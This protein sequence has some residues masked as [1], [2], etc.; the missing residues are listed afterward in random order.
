MKRTPAV[1]AALAATAALAFAGC[2]DDD[3]DA[4]ALSGATGATGVGS[5]S[6]ESKADFIA[7][8]DQICADLEDQ[9]IQDLEGELPKG[10]GAPSGDEADALAEEIVIPNLQAQH[11]A[12][13]ALD[14]PA[15]E[16]E[17]INEIL[18][19]LQAG[20]DDVSD[21]PGSLFSETSTPIDEA[22][23]AAL[24]YGLEECGS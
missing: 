21:D 7:A 15:G 22:S 19:K 9:G 3:D 8:A 4:D 13:A 18:D 24:D 20:I 11:D 10:G 2:G 23:Q 14:Q 17:E 6:I 5:A 12:I 16:E 1:I